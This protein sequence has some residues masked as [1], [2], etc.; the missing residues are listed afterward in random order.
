M[1]ES[2]QARQKTLN[3]RT[4]SLQHGRFLSRAINDCEH[5]QMGSE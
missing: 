3:Y 1:P 5:L 2:S 4:Q